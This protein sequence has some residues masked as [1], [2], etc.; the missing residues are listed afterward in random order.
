MW[1]EGE[2]LGLLR[3]SVFEIKAG[4]SL[5]VT[6]LEMEG[7]GSMGSTCSEV[8]GVVIWSGWIACTVRETYTCAKLVLLISK[9][10]LFY[11]QN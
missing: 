5:D 11:M 2:G 3:F 9:K 1:F 4:I 6:L 7:F 10:V 8:S